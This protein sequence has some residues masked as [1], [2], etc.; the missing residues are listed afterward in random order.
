MPHLRQALSPL[1]LLC[2]AATWLIWGST[3]LAIRFALDGFPPF[4]QMGSR[5]V[6]AGAALVAWM[7]WR[8]APWPTLRQWRNAVVVG[9]L[10][11]VIGGGGTA[12]AEQTVPSGLIVV[13]VAVMPALITLLN[14]LA[15]IRPG[16]LEMAGMAIGFTGVL[17]LIR[18]EAF[19]SSPVG[20][21]AISLSTCSWA[22]GS[23]LSQRSCP[24]APGAMGYGSQM[25]VGGVLLLL[26]SA[27]TGEHPRWP[28]TSLALASWLYLIV[29]G[30]LIAFNAYMYLL[31]HASPAVAS[32]YAFVNPVIALL[33]GIGF[34][35]E[36]VTGGEWLAAGV[37]LTGVV[38]LLSGR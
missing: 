24:L 31:G 4:F 32:S 20:L 30:S 23:V 5:F 13:F 15:G 25:L 34:G 37:I 28:P 38:L 3:Y 19:T 1:V 12:Y 17:L 33:L 7:R 16:R 6:I 2:L 18:G 27:A 35:H 29:F 21:A 14:R 9:S 10:L 36:A 8:G 26:L 11:L 22:L